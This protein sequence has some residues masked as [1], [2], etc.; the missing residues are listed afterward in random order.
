[1][2]ENHA[3]ERPGEETDRVRGKGRNDPVQWIPRFRKKQGTEDQSRGRPVN[4][5]LVPLG[6]C[7]RHGRGDHAL[8]P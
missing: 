4:K 6:D 5:E 8:Y 2:T 7:A 3:S 1:M